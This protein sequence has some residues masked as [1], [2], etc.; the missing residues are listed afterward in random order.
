MAGDAFLARRE[1]RQH[2]S[3][4]GGKLRWLI[5]E[6]NLR[7]P[8]RP[9]GARRATPRPWRALS[10]TSRPRLARA[11]E[12]RLQ[13]YLDALHGIDRDAIEAAVNTIRD[14]VQYDR[15]PLPSMVRALALQ[16]TKIPETLL[17]L[18][19]LRLSVLRLRRSMP[20]SNKRG[21]I[22]RTRCSSLS[23]WRCVIAQGAAEGGELITIGMRPSRADRPPRKRKRGVGQQG[24][25]DATWEDLKD[26][27]IDRAGKSDPRGD[28]VGGRARRVL[29]ARCERVAVIHG[30]KLYGQ[31]KEAV[32]ICA[33]GRKASLQRGDA[34]AAVEFVLL[35]HV[36]GPLD[37][38]SSHPAIV[39]LEGRLSGD[40][41]D[42]II[43][44]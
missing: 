9:K 11:S 21:E 20:H 13:T 1:R 28:S 19:S 6:E 15:L 43:P 4:S 40:H 26:G 42:L 14:C 24:K 33:D 37:E 22:I 30:Q 18:K 29:S 25:G 41:D 12:E 2:D 34:R 7:T 3:C 16:A 35:P 27:G 5:G 23:C 17:R 39:M 32:G 44:Q 10:A 8:R 38:Y 36:A 31:G